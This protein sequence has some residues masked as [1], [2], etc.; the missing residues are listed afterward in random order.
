M[1]RLAHHLHT[2]FHHL[3]VIALLSLSPVIIGA[4]LS[5]G[6]A[7]AFRLDLTS[8]L[9]NLPVGACQDRHGSTHERR[10]G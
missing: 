6:L 3:T 1:L 9:D 4:L 2:L 10:A 8:V 5:L 7:R